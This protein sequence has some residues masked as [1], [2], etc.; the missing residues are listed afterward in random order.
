METIKE[1]LE[2][3]GYSEITDLGINDSVTINAEGVEELT[4]ERVGDTKISVAHYYTQN[5]DL[6][7][8]PEIVF[9]VD[10]N[11]G[12]M[13]VEYTHDPFTYDSNENGLPEAQ[14]FSIQW[15]KNLRK[16]GFVG[17]ARKMAEN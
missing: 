9:D 12:W 5:G 7:R 13:A 8:D 11:R 2:I 3:L 1:I 15:N 6:M 4:I 14:R 10:A 17:E 16:Q